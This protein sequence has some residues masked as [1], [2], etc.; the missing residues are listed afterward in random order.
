MDLRETEKR[1]WLAI[2]VELLGSED[3]HHLIDHLRNYFIDRRWMN[4]DAKVKRFEE[5]V[6]IVR[7]KIWLKV[8]RQIQADVRRGRR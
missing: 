2:W 6:H 3:G 7:R 5:A 8:P 4:T 1:I